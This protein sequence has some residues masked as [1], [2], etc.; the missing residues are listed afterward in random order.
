LTS[1]IALVCQALPPSVAAQA[2]LVSRLLRSLPPERYRLIAATAAISRYPGRGSE[3]LPADTFVLSAELQLNRGSRFGLLPWRI[4]LNLAIAVAARAGRIARILRA[5][6]CDGVVAFTGDLADMIASY[7]AARH[8]GA[9]FYPYVL[10]DFTFRELAAAARGV[11]RWLER[12]LMRDATAVVTLNELMREELRRRHGINAIVIHNPCELDAYDATPPPPRAHSGLRIVYTGS[13]Y[14][15][16]YDAFQNLLA[17]LEALPGVLPLEIYS[18]QP[19]EHLTAHGIVGRLVHRA[20]LPTSTVPIVQQAAD[21]LFLPL[22]F[23]S[24]YPEVVRTAAP[25]K[26][27]EYLAAGRPILVHAPR[28]SFTAAYFRKH[29]CGIVVDEPDRAAL[30]AALERLRDDSTLRERLGQ[31]ARRRAE[32]DF[33]AHRARETF[34]RVVGIWPKGSAARDRASDSRG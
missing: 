5:E 20:T 23:A 11:A 22:A 26:L 1:R 19:A 6:K 16:H 13:I 21:V 32:A 24:P 7:L 15:A 14:D 31:A 33:D 27:G 2:T 30:R 8:V 18:D 3:L 28:D 9:R 17:A 12:R 34:M 25:F 4:R 10:D 29:G